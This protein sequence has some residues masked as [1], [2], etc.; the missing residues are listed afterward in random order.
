MF[1]LKHRFFVLWFTQRCGPIQT[2]VHELIEHNTAGF[3]TKEY[4][5]PTCIRPD[6]I[7]E[8]GDVQHK[9]QGVCVY[10]LHINKCWGNAV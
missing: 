4:C 6:W 3:R 5:K 8:L 10:I 2:S 1:A 7:C 9:Q